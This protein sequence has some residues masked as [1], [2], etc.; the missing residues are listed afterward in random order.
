MSAGISCVLLD[1]S[2][3]H[4]S[5]L[6]HSESGKL[7]SFGCG[8]DG[9]LGHGNCEV[10]NNSFLFAFNFSAFPPRGIY[11]NVVMVK[12]GTFGRLQHDPLNDI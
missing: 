2:T 3:L 4:V 5:F 8:S 11:H 6:S 1:N 10:G 9:Q 12:K 7:Y